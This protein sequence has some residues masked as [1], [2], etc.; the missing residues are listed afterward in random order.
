MGLVAAHTHM[1]DRLTL[2]GT[3]YWR[4]GLMWRQYAGGKKLYFDFAFG[5][6]GP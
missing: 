5:V 6:G 2:K 3:I 4:A 1:V